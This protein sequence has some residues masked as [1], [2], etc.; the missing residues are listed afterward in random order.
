MFHNSGNQNAYR[1]RLQQLQVP[2]YQTQFLHHASLSPRQDCQ[3]LSHLHPHYRRQAEDE[4]SLT[5]SSTAFHI[6]SY[7]DSQHPLY[8]MVSLHPRSASFTIE[9]QVNLKF[10]IFNFENSSSIQ[11]Q[12]L[13][14]LFHFFSALASA[15]SG[16]EFPAQTAGRR[17]IAGALVAHF[18][19]QIRDSHRP[20]SVCPW[21]PDSLV[22]LL[23]KTWSLRCLFAHGDPV[24]PT[25]QI[26]HTLAIFPANF[27]AARPWCA[28]SAAPACTCLLYHLLL[29]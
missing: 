4:A 2:P 22:S 16:I 21:S 14:Y 17:Q 13:I 6:S 12:M 7:T 20:G 5:Y 28:R 8:H 3:I 23:M 19:Q 29:I 27:T 10:Y 26:I 11:G 18:S 1:G 15:Q 24:A 25:A 9:F